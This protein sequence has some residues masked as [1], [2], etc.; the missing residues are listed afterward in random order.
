M[1]RHSLAFRIVVVFSGLLAVVLLASFVLVSVVNLRISRQT[2]AQALETGER[3]F[4]RL[5]DQRG[6]QLTV[7]AQVLARDF[8]LRDAIATRDNE[9]L[10]SALDNHGSRIHADL[11]IFSG[12]DNII[13]AD[14]VNPARAG[15]PYPFG[16]LI[17]AAGKRG[18]S[19]GIERVD[20]RLYQ[21]VVV[22]VRAPIVIG[23]V[24]MGFEINDRTVADLR[25][26]S[27]LQVTFLG[28]AP[29]DGRRVLASTLPAA[30]RDAL[31]GKMTELRAVGRATLGDEDYETRLV[32]LGDSLE[33][34][35]EVLLA[36]SLAEIM[37]P[38]YRLQITLAMLAFAAL[39]VC[40]LA[41]M[42]L[43]G[44]ITQPL[45][46]L[47]AIADRIQQGDYQQAINRQ[48]QSEIG[49]LA[50]SLAHMQTAIAE[51]EAEIRTLAF[52][53]R[54]TGLPNRLRFNQ[55]LDD[56]IT[57]AQTSG[58]S[59]TVLILNLDRFQ[60][61]NDT[62]GHPM[63]DR[64]LIEV[65]RRLVDAV[66]D[67]DT[68]ARLSGDEFAVLLPAMAVDA[69]LPVLERIHGMFDHP[70]QLDGRPLDI[71]AGMGAAGYPEHARVSIDLLRCA[72]LALYRAKAARQRH[73]IY[74]S[75][76]QHARETHLSLL[77]ELQTAV[78]QNELKLCYQPKVALADSSA[79]EAEALVRW[80]HP[81]RG[82][83]SPGEFIPFAEQTGYIKEVTQWVLRA[84]IHQIGVWLQTGRAIKVS[85]NLSTLDLLD[86]ALPTAVASLLEQA[87]VPPALLCLEITESGLMEDPT[88]ALDT[89]NRLRNMG[90]ALAID[91]YGTGYSSL[92]Y[93]RR[94]PVTELKIDRAFVIELAHNES[95]AQIVQSTI[96]LGHRLGLKVV[97]E[98]VEDHAT[99]EVL[100][101]LGCDRI[102]GYVFAK[103]ML[104]D[105]FVAWHT[106]HQ[107]KTAP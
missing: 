41:G 97:A 7:G 40:L 56:A 47:A 75:G 49:Q 74:N 107:Q 99:V 38:V 21:L 13:Q 51:R 1:R 42:R 16:S 81:E 76:M 64:V 86:P 60:Q 67:E 88:L 26:V 83:V 29:G 27:G 84:A 69:A 6:E 5:L 92:A 17:A 45:R 82:F 12:L 57:A 24:T 23:W 105:D 34:P 11:V 53:D 32:L 18:G 106:A 103:P 79:D 9:T 100:R 94:L 101:R 3:V 66:R 28:D 68:V 37:A 87:G 44:R 48:D 80:I 10:L 50:G 35:V 72:D 8:G 2:A 15:Q 52:Q 78:Q 89:L 93:I 19:T 20:G 39:A 22:P 85:V 77:G 31:G 98:G 30:Q 104:A 33:G 54:L 102:Q 96:D 70:L 95:D 59:L 58:E 25:A 63:G 62:L 55:L 90:L 73:L 36:R 71:R 46:Q 4:R 91:D 65:G 61:I 43:A 14:T